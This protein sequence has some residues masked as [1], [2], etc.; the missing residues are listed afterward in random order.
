M[1]VQNYKAAIVWI[2]YN[3]KYLHNKSQVVEFVAYMFNKSQKTVIDDCL[4]HIQTIKD[5]LAKL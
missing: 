2:C 3:D 4:E 5:S 1:L